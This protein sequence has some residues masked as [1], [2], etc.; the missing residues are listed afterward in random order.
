MPAFDAVLFDFDGVLLDSEPMHCACWAEVLEPLGV[1]LTWDFYS[2]HCIGIDDREMLRMMATQSDPPR[3]WDDLWAQYP[4]KKRLFQQRMASNPAF[5]P[6]MPTLLDELRAAHKLAVVSSSGI[7]E[8]E[9]LLVAGGLRGYF[10][11]V[12][13]GNDVKRQKPDPEPYLLAASRL[14]VKMP[15]VVEDS[16]AGVAAGRAAGFEVLRV[17]SPAEVP[18][19]VRR[20]VLCT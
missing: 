18:D 2:A 14:G 19:A 6:E 16:E 10:G 9:P 20:V 7:T 15:L 5:H 17:T 12:V 11:T 1:H 4:A 13:G 3:V 8:I